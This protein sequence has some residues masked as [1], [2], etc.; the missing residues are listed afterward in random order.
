MNRVPFRGRHPLAALLS[1]AA[2]KQKI[3]IAMLLAT[4]IAGIRLVIIFYER[5]QGAVQQTKK[6][7]VRPLNPDYY[8]TPKKLYPYDLKSAKQLTKQPA[9]VRV[10]Y[11]YSYYPYDPATHH[12]NFS[13]EAGKL[14]PIQKLEIKDVIFGVSPKDPGER[15][16][17]AV[18]EQGGKPYA[19]PIGTEK[20]GDYKFFSDDMLFIEDPHQL[21]KHWPADVWRAIDQ[22]QVKPGMNELQADFA[23]GIGLLEAGGDSIDRT[24]DYPNGGKPLSISYHDGKAVEIRPGT[25]N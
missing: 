18:F 15:Q 7:E 17:L 11:A 23:V 25:A 12:A 9:W 16:V 2:M 1:Y 6:P 19:T 10:G 20:D 8:V 13:H 4:L 5:H 24:L 14:L 22:H 21:Y 3:R